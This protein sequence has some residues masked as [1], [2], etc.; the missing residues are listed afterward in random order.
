[1]NIV[2]K[3]NLDTTSGN[4][5]N[6]LK[7]MEFSL[8]SAVVRNIDVIK[9]SCEKS[10]PKSAQKNMHRAIRYFKKIGKIRCFIFGAD[11]KTDDDTTR[12]LIERA[13][14]IKYDTDLD[15]G[16]EKIALVYVK[17]AT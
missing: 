6:I 15:S 1:M 14:Y 9:F 16:N 5:E 3:I 8:A 7:Q 11:F 13:E 17:S 4:Y 10:V 2:E 12:Y